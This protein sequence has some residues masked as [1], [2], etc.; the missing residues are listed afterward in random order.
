[1]FCLKSFCNAVLDVLNN[2][3]VDLVYGFATI[4]LRKQEL[5]ALLYLCYWCFMAVIGLCLFLAV[6]MHSRV[7][8]VFVRGGRTLTTFSFLFFLFLFYEGRRS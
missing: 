8:K 6:L 5:V 4:S 1:M 7:Q 3:F 2:S